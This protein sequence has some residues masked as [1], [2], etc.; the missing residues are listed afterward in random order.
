MPAHVVVHDY[1]GLF[2]IIDMK[3]YLF[4]LQTVF[5]VRVFLWSQHLDQVIKVSVDFLLLAKLSNFC[6]PP[7]GRQRSV[8]QE[9]RSM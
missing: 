9:R 1:N 5:W 7:E 8:V 6:D 2:L 4:Y 3:N